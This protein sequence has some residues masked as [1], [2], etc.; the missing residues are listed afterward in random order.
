M[1]LGASGIPVSLGD[2]GS[3]NSLKD[4]TKRQS[5]PWRLVFSE[6]AAGVRKNLG[7]L[8]EGF[9]TNLSEGIEGLEPIKESRTTQKQSESNQKFPSFKVNVILNLNLNLLFRSKR[10]HRVGMWGEGPPL[11]HGRR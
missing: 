2:M 6:V 1:K 3:W 11:C 4:E 8:S 10:L 9:G 7:S 5:I